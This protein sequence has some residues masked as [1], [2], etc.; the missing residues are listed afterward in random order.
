MS[1]AKGRAVREEDVLGLE[2]KGVSLGGTFGGT[3]GGNGSGSRDGA[4]WTGEEAKSD[5]DTRGSLSLLSRWLRLRLPL[6]KKLNPDD[7]LGDPFSGPRSD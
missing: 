6:F 5:I 7:F 3:I 4:S 2:S 1:L